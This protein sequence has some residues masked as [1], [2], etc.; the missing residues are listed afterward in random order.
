MTTHTTST[1]VEAL[2]AEWSQARAVDGTAHSACMYMVQVGDR[3][4]R[5]LELAHAALAT[6]EP[7]LTNLVVAAID[8]YK[9]GLA[10]EP[11]GFVSEAFDC[12]WASGDHER[13]SL[14]FCVRADAAPTAEPARKGWQLVPQEPT[15]A[16]LLAAALTPGMKAV[17]G[18][19]ATHQLRSSA[20]RINKWPGD[21]APIAQAYRAML[22]A[23]KGRP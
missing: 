11:L 15:D 21:D 3:M 19:L 2:R 9:A 14:L 23:A 18:M 1:A 20:N 10:G 6:A 4:I 16:M 7:P 5:A 12:G 8:G 22:A 13:R 17:D